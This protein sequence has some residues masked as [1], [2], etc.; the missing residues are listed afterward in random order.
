VDD[1]FH[2]YILKRLEQLFMTIYFYNN[3]GK[4][5]IMGPFTGI[6]IECCQHLLTKTKN[7]ERE[8]LATYDD[9]YGWTINKGMLKGNSYT[10]F[11][12]VT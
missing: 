2:A 10:N 9:A 4:S 5:A 8:P 6:K 11:E 12:I 3:N 7:W 1:I